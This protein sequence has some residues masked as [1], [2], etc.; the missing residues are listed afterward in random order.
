MVAII[1]KLA[2]LVKLK[3]L[4]FENTEAQRL[5]TGKAPKEVDVDLSYSAE[6]RMRSA[7]SID[8]LVSFFVKVNGL[9]KASIAK[10]A[11]KIRLSYDV[12][13]A[14]PGEGV[15]MT[16]GLVSAFA[17]TNGIYNAFPYFREY[18]QSTCPRLGL[19]P[20]LAPLIM[21][22]DLFDRLREEVASEQKAPPEHRVPEEKQSLTLV[23]RE[24][25]AS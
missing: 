4:Y 23:R 8:A 11:C 13:E 18:L 3:E 14:K 9:D 12:K 15:E 6:G 22:S 25:K 17:R 1:R 20:I 16:E 24:Q 10:I 2:N 5:L 19:P 7:N 21:A